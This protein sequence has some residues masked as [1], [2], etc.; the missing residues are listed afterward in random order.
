MQHII[1][2]VVLF[3]AFV[4]MTPTAPACSLFFRLRPFASLPTPCP[5]PAM[6]MPSADERVTLRLK[7]A[8]GKDFYVESTAVTKQKMKVMGQEV[9]QNQEQT[10]VYHWQ[11]E[12]MTKNG[13]W[14]VRVR[15]LRII[16]K[17]DIGGNRINYDSCSRST[18]SPGIDLFDSL[19]NSP[20]KNAS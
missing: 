16:L 15:T 10:F 14:I 12:R 8:K 3:V 20:L 2:G 4:G 5:P 1:L 6:H 9:L 13:D 18:R 17:V 11:P 7:F 19:L